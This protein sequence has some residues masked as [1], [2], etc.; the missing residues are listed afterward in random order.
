[1]ATADAK[2]LVLSIGTGEPIVNAGADGNGTEG[3]NF[4]RTGSFTNPGR[5]GWTATVDYGDSGGEQPLA[6]NTTAKTFR[7][8]HTYADDGV[9]TVTVEITNNAGGV[10]RGAFQVDVANAPPVVTAADD[11]TAE[12][13]TA[14]DF[15][16]GSFTDPG[17]DGPWTVT[18]D[19]GDGET[20]APSEVAAPGDLADLNHAY[21]DNGTYTMTVSWPR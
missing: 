2:E 5:S 21:A 1:V 14:Q 6:L 9:Y 4:A 12:E 13:G 20:S 15:S 17:P 19:W 11:Q 7:L 3:S 10:G 8:D 16:L 18:V